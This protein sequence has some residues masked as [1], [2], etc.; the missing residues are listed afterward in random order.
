MRLDGAFP[1][2]VRNVMKVPSHGKSDGILTTLTYQ[3]CQ[4]A[5]QPLLLMSQHHWQVQ[6]VSHG[7]EISKQCTCHPCS[8]YSF[9]VMPT[10][11][12]QSY[13]ADIRSTL[14]NQQLMPLEHEGQQGF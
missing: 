1:R 10:K 12:V 13:A 14:M 5:K 6:E 3:E 4:L 11:T 8:T 7:L 9:I 2:A